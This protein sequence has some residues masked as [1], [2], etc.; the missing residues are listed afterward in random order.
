MSNYYKLKEQHPTLVD[1]FFAFSKSQLAE[2]IQKHNLQDKKIV[3][4][5]GGLFG[6]Q[7]GIQKLYDDYEAISKQ[8]T[9]NCEPQE[10]YDYEFVNHECSYV[11]DDEEAIKLV[12]SYF[13]DEKAKL[14]KRRFAV[15]KIENL[16]FN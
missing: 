5:D 9:D 7:E 12:V 4:A 13:G 11:G 2:G 10:V 6:T 8:I 15:T 16:K 1:C 3:R 14:V